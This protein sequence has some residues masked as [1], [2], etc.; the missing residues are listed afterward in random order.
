MKIWKH[1]QGYDVRSMW[2]IKILEHENIEPFSYCLYFD[3][4]CTSLFFG[5]YAVQ[6]SDRKYLL[7]TFETLL[8]VFVNANLFRKIY[9]YMI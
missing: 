4:R 8:I 9:N 2:W 1:N 5:F 7:F 6:I 3:N